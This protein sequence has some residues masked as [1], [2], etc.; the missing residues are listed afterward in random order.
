M[1]KNLFISKIIVVAMIFKYCKVL[2]YLNYCISMGLIHTNHYLDFS[3]DDWKQISSNPT[4]FEAIV[5]NAVIE[6]RDT[7]HKE[8]KIVFKNGGQI[9]YI[10]SIGKYRLSWDDEDLVS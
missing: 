6:L 7:G 10:R 9:K 8:Q 5:D 1:C 2:R 3:S 4:V